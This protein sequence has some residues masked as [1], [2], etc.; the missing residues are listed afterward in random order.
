[1]TRNVRQTLRRR[2]RRSSEGTP[3]IDRIHDWVP[4]SV[5]RKLQ[6]E[7]SVEAHL[8]AMSKPVQTATASFRRKPVRLYA[9]IVAVLRALSCGN[10]GVSEA[11]KKVLMARAWASNVDARRGRFVDCRVRV[12][13]PRRA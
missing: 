8:F 5:R 13:A 12:G 9:V 7:W 6:D 4:C 2:R 1:M 10:R 11:E 3:H